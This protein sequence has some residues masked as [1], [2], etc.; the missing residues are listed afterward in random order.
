MDTRMVLKI[1]CGEMDSRW[2][3]ERQGNLICVTGVARWYSIVYSCLSF[4]HLFLPFLQ[5]FRSFLP[6]LFFLPCILN[7]YFISHIIFHIFPCF[8]SFFLSPSIFVFL[9]SPFSHC[10]PLASIVLPFTYSSSANRPT[11][12]TLRWATTFTTGVPRHCLLCKNYTTDRMT[13]NWFHCEHRCNIFARRIWHN[14]VR[15]RSLFQFLPFHSHCFCY[16]DRYL[17]FF[18]ARWYEIS[19]WTLDRV[20]AWVTEWLA[21]NT[22]VSYWVS[23]SG[24]VGERGGGREVTSYELAETV[25][26]LCR[27]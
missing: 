6:N 13:Y 25:F 7:S 2:R 8:L 9:I 22:W 1:H 26:V 11:S 12:P 16:F 10:F 23:E 4:L 14:I 21:V 27:I 3:D 17:L 20:R 24:W 5:S 18:W 19:E 15:L